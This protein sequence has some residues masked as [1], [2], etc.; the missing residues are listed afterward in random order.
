VTSA[1]ARRLGI[2]VTIEPKE[3]TIPGLVEALAAAED[4]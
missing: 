4:P 2:P 3:H 1:T